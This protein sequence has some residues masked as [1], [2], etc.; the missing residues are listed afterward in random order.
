MRAC[1]NFFQQEIV[2]LSDA[3]RDLFHFVQSFDNFLKVN[4]FLD[5]W[6][7]EDPYPFQIY[8]YKN[9]FNPDEKR[10]IQNNKKLTIRNNRN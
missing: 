4:D 3:A 9:L 8:F 5:I 7:V 6:M 2:N 1:K 10:K